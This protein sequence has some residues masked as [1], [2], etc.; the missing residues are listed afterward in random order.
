MRAVGTLSLHNHVQFD[1]TPF[2]STPES[3]V[4]LLTWFNLHLDSR[5]FISALETGEKHDA[6]QEQRLIPGYDSLLFNGVG[7]RIRPRRSD[8]YTR[9]NECYPEELRRKT[10]VGQGPD[11][12]PYERAESGRRTERFQVP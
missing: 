3:S 1:C 5:F 2:C 7:V 4:I 11:G 6:S 10:Q 9:G 12:G 8:Y